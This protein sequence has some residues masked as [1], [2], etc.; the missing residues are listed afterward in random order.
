MKQTIN[1][2]EVP[3]LRDEDD[4]P[5]N[6]YDLT[7][8]EHL[9]IYEFEAKDYVEYLVLSLVKAGQ[10]LDTE[11]G[12][13]AYEH[14]DK[15]VTFFHC[16]GFSGEITKLNSETEL[17]TFLNKKFHMTLKGPFKGGK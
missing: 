13:I 9:C 1:I 16:C 5:L 17:R 10:C 7:K 12:L 2:Y 4:Y 14:F 11:G 15:S 8:A 3:H 6:G